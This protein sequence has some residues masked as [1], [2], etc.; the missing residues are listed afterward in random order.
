MEAPLHL[1]EAQP[2]VLLVTPDPLKLFF[3]VLLRDAGALL[4]LLNALREDLV[5][6]TVD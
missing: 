3:A 6:A 1:S 5:N 4:P 2:G